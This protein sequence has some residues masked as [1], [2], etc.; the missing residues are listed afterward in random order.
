MPSADENTTTPA[1]EAVRAAGIAHQVVEYGRVG[2]IEEAAERR[3]VALRQVIKSLVVRL[4]A[5]E[6]MLVLVPGDRALDWARLRHL[7]GVSR[8]TLADADEAQH[9]TGY[10][11]GA[12]TPLGTTKALPV[13]LD[14]SASGT[15]SVGGGRPGV[16]I[17]LDAADLARIT[18]ATVA[19]VTRPA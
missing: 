2:S 14:A 3:G 13:V 17:H 12:I 11:P 9:A 10:P 16:A 8:M 7:A 1:V 18:Q 5:G 6:F 4:G 19:E 15:L